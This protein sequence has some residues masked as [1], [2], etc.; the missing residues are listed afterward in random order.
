[1]FY[2]GFYL[3]VE[4]SQSAFEIHITCLLHSLSYSLNIRIVEYIAGQDRFCK[5]EQKA[6]IQPYNVEKKN[7]EPFLL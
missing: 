2:V 4:C 1:M 5:P 6:L 3:S 7:T